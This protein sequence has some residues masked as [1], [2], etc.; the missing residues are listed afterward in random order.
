MDIDASADVPLLTDEDMQLGSGPTGV[1]GGIRFQQVILSA[2]RV[3][4]AKILGNWLMTLPLSLQS[5]FLAKSGGSRRQKRKMKRRRKSLRTINIS[6][7][8]LPNFS[9]PRSQSEQPLLVKSAGFPRLGRTQMMMKEQRMKKQKVR[10][11]QN[12]RWQKMTRRKVIGIQMMRRKRQAA[13]QKI[14]K[15]SLRAKVRRKK[16]PKRRSPQSMRVVSA[17]VTKKW[18]KR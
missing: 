8:H 14:Q 9:L 1:L 13:K 4:F 7:S 17:K 16:M 15:R 5:H 3:S 11:P 18:P 6:F 2:H 10:I 12:Q